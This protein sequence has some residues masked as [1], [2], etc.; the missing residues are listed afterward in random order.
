MPNQ[1][2]KT[3]YAALRCQHDC[4]TSQRAATIVVTVGES[5]SLKRKTF[6]MSVQSNRPDARLIEEAFLHD[7]P[8]AQ[9]S[10]ELVTFYDPKS[11]LAS[12]TDSRNNLPL[13]ILTAARFPGMSGLDLL[14]AVKSQRRL[15]GIPVLVF[16]NYLPPN[17]VEE[18]FAEYAS[19]V[20]ELPGRLAEL[21]AT[22]RLVKAYWLGIAGLPI[23]RSELSRHSA[24]K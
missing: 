15:R 21:E 12:L 5:K 22:V 18:L 3:P 17:E 16:G 24:E 4:G 13:L 19:S 14:K 8:E 20:I 2:G 23:S 7:R 6:V 9:E 1:E 11:A 10:V